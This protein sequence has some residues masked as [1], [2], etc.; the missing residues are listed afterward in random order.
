MTPKADLAVGFHLFQHFN[1]N[2][3]YNA[4][5]YL[6]VIMHAIKQSLKDAVNDLLFV[7][8]SKRTGIRLTNFSHNDFVDIILLECVGVQCSMKAEPAI[9][10]LAWLKANATGRFKV[11]QCW[12]TLYVEFSRPTDAVMYKLCGPY[13]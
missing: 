12:D 5:Y 8:K 10:T 13:V 7:F 11:N 6:G 9:A 1:S 4:P 3:L 2:W